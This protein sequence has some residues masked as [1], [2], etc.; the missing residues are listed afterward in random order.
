MR[1]R[2]YP[3]E[4]APGL[5]LVTYGNGVA[6][7][8]RARARLLSEGVSAHVLDL[9]WLVP[10]P[11]DDVVRE[12]KA[13]GRVLVVDEARRSG[14]VGEALL[15]GLVERAPGVKTAR[16]AAADCFIPLGDAAELVRE[17]LADERIEIDA[18]QRS[19][20]ETTKTRDG[21]AAFKIARE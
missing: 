14:N 11:W 10:L 13:A 4:S 12:A 18:V 9:R 3:L 20:D 5:L 2:L 21:I 19:R 7:C 15:A 17:L 16:V 8:L 6:M 1:A